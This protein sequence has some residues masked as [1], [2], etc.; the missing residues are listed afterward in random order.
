MHRDFAVHES[1]Y[2]AIGPTVKGYSNYFLGT[3]PN[4]I[5]PVTTT[6]AER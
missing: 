5:Q 4:M 6:T 3:N 2:K 1:N